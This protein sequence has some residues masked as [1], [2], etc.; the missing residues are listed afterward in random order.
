M[1]KRQTLTRDAATGPMLTLTGWR[2][3]AVWP[4]GGRGVNFTPPR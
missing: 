3:E 2:A 4:G 1:D